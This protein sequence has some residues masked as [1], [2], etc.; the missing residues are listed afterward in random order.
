MM[1]CVVC[2]A[3]C[4]MCGLWCVVCG[5]VCV[6]LCVVC[7]VRV[8]SVCDALRFLAISCDACGACDGSDACDALLCFAMPCHALGGD[9]VLD[10]I[11][12]SSRSSV[13]TR[14]RAV[15]SKTSQSVHPSR[16]QRPWRPRC[17]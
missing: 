9:A 4:A 10:A 1:L 8:V 5:V 14:G 7:V 16:L 2:G 15:T 12:V 6:R 3:W 17:Q 11:V 13:V